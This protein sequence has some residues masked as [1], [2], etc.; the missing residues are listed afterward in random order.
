MARLT[1]GGS[2]RDGE[3]AVG[4]ESE[5]LPVGA[6]T[7]VG[8]GARKSAPRSPRPTAGDGSAP[9]ESDGQAGSVQSRTRPASATATAPQYTAEQQAAEQQHA[10]QPAADSYRGFTREELIADYRLA[11]TSR[12]IDDREIML[13][14]QSG[15]L[16]DLRC[17]PR[18]APARPRPFAS[19]RVRLVL[20]VLP[21][22]GPL[23]RPRRHAEG[24]PPAGRGVSGRPEL[25]RETDAVA[26]GGQAA[27]HRLADEPDRKSMPAGRRLCGGRPLH[28]TEEAPGMHGLW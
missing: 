11:C 12:A 7:M 25:G 27:Q 14:K 4:D 8:G 26:L 3:P 17:R 20:S 9:H 1:K 16:S 19:L 10:S 18:G 22:P 28:R 21:G 13:Q 24:N 2:R 23:P 15:L 6:D 5:A